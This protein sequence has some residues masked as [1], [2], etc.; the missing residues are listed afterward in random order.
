MHYSA[1]LKVKRTEDVFDYVPIY[2]TK[3]M[4]QLLPKGENYVEITGTIKGYNVGKNLALFVDTL[5]MRRLACEEYENKV[6]LKGIFS[7]KNS[8][9]IHKSY[10]DTFYVT[11]KNNKKEAHIPI[12]AWK[13]T[14]DSI[15]SLKPGQI[16][17]LVGRIQ[18]RKS[19]QSFDIDSLKS[20]FSFRIN[21]L[22]ISNAK[23]VI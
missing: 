9:K 1:I 20:S 3:S 7:K 12:I 14:N 22:S 8:D 2:L 16:I 6:F 10:L 17:N 18:N 23:D 4:F 21:C 15:F 19:M 13:K 11:V 5:I